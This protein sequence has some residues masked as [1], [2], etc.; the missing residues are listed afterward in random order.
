MTLLRSDLTSCTLIWFSFKDVSSNPATHA[1]KV[2]NR[3]TH[4]SI[5]LKLLTHFRRGSKQLYHIYNYCHHVPRLASNRGFCKKSSVT[6]NPKSFKLLDSYVNGAKKLVLPHSVRASPPYK[7]RIRNVACKGC[8]RYRKAQ[9]CV[10][11]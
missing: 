4:N 6:C 2:I 8:W 1:G 5:Q 3:R 7:L 10:A 9:N 11:L